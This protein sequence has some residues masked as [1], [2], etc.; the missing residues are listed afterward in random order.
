MSAVD[1]RSTPFSID[2]RAAGRSVR[3]ECLEVLRQ[4]P[5]KRL[6]A[7][8]RLDGAG[9]AF[10]LFFGPGARRRFRRE[11]S[12]LACVAK[13]GVPTPRMLAEGS[14]EG[15]WWIAVEWLLGRPATLEDADGIVRL[16]AALHAAG[17]VQ[18]DPH[19]GNFLAT[20]ERL[21]LLDGGAVDGRRFRRMLGRR[22][23][24]AALARQLAALDADAAAVERGYGLYC[25][26]R[27][28][29]ADADEC[30]R[31]R[32]L[33]TRTQ[34]RRVRRFLAKTLRPCT[35]FDLR[36][37]PDHDV[38]YERAGM[39]P[40][41]ERLLEAPDAAVEGAT[42][43]KD[44]NT[45]T[46]VR[47]EPS[48]GEREGPAPRKKEPSAG[49]RVR[50]SVALEFPLR[51]NSRAEGGD[52]LAPRNKGT[53]GFVVKRYNA[54]RHRA[55]RAWVNGHRLCFRGIP[56]ARPV[57]VMLPRRRGPAYLVLED[58]GGSTLDEH[59]ASHGLDDA[60]VDAV[61][62]LFEALSLE[63][64]THRDTKATNFIVAEGRVSLVDLDA[65]RPAR[66][67]REI[68]ADRKRFLENW[69]GAVVARFAQAFAR[70]LHLGTPS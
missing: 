22:G 35:Q 13:T 18:N 39:S 62:D 34:R 30:A 40:A 20:D 33:V 46:V 63:G 52:G 58:L 23:S 60:T 61:V 10:K 54:K 8:G 24:F 27:N 26:A 2:G 55:R 64:L 48:A 47:V 69:D 56:T 31:L 16:N 14:F 44:G 43:V 51:E 4:L 57:A 59:V 53:G 65:L 50:P 9:V 29:Q 36:R 38:V 37:G 49:E 32:R 11:R 5:G 17:V 70:R 66:S 25:E 12:G 45:A 1:D 3:I 21:F 67:P 15:G 28:W 6:V 7:R 19:L 41:L 42:R 68:A